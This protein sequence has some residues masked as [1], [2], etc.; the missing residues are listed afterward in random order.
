MSLKKI[1]HGITG[2]RGECDLGNFEA[3][4]LNNSSAQKSH[5]STPAARWWY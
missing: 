2:A 3:I 1:I 4:R 5:W